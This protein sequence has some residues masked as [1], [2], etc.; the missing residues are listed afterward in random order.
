[1][2]SLFGRNRL[3]ER[4]EK[5]E[6][7]AVLDHIATVQ[8]WL[9]DYDHGTLKTDKETGR[10]Q[11]YNQDFF[12]RILGYKE[13]PASP[14]TFEPKHTTT[15]GQYPDAVLRYTDA[16]KSIDNISAVVELKGAKISLD[17][18]QQREGN[19][20]PVQ[21]AFKYKP[22]YASCPFVV[23]SNFWEFR[24]YNDNQLDYEAWTLRDLV[25][26]TDDYIKFKQWYVLLHADN[27]VAAQGKSA[28]ERLL[29]DIR[30]KQEDV[31]KKFYAEYKAARDTLLQDIWRKNEK[32][33]TNFSVAI[34]KAQTIIDRIMFACFAEDSG[35]LPDNILARVK[36][37]AE[38]SAYND[39]L[40][41]E[42]KDFFIKIDRGSSK[43]GIPQG[44]NGGL[45]AYDPMVDA[46]EISDEALDALIAFGRYDFKEDLQVNILGHIFE[47]SITDLEEIKRKVWDDSH[48]DDGT[49]AV[50]KRGKRKQDGIYYTPD[51]VVR[52]I[53]DN[54]VGAFL[55]QKE[56]ELLAKHKLTDRLGER[57]YE[58][59]ERAAYLEYQYVLQNIKVIDPA[60]GSGA[61]LVYVFDYLLA[62]NNRVDDI[63]GGGLYS[64][65]SFVR[66]IL[67]DNIYG[68]DLNDESVEITKLSLWLKTA[69]RDKKLTT[70][71]KNIKVGNSII[72]DPL[73]ATDKAFNWEEAFPEVLK[74]G[75][76]DVVV[77]N[78]P[79]GVSF[80][81]AE[82]KHLN[83]FDALV[84]DFE[85]YVYFIS[86][87]RKILADGGRLTY[88]FPNTFL[89]NVYGVR[90]RK[91]LF[92]ETSLDSLLDLS[93]DPTF[94]DA[95][96][97]TIVMSLTKEPGEYQTEM[98]V[99][100]E[101]DKAI[102]TFQSLNKKQLITSI[103]N[104][105]ALFTRLPEESQVIDKIKSRS[106]SLSQ[107]MDVSQGYIPY[108]RSDLVKAYGKAAG[109]S[110][111]DNRE[112]HSPVK[113][114]DTYKRD[115]AGRELN[116]YSIRKL[117]KAQ[118]VKYGPHVA[119]YVDPKFFSDPRIIVREI[120][121]THLYAAFTDEEL[122]T[123]PS[124]IN[125]V[126]IDPALDVQAVLAI[127]NSK[128][129]G[130]FHN[131]TSPKAKKGL[132]PKVLVGDVRN[133]PLILPIDTT[134]LS[135]LAV[136]M[137]ATWKDLQDE[138]DNFKTLIRSD[139]SLPA[140]PTTLGFWWRLEFDEFVKRLVKRKLTLSKKNDLLLIFK[141]Y[142][143]TCVPLADAF[144]N[145][146]KKVDGI[147]YQLYGLTPSE[148]A[149]V[150]AF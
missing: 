92:E 133:I 93:N 68:V 119:S 11:Q 9:N 108:R 106:Q 84:P 41:E 56:A 129:I 107:L 86:L 124:I 12:M 3:R 48:P 37:S 121:A 101:D 112:W 22:Q 57:G 17:R 66:S 70:L 134:E 46:L 51:Y 54:S 52:Y 5:I 33:R 45:F 27:M 2:A 148:I 120:T 14:F 82:K 64:T 72:S 81:D 60:C 10:E 97:R 146:D 83:S 4:A 115:L 114:D 32:T 29:T 113:L 96:V 7:S 139:L 128:L 137:A 19:L 55:R 35:L 47:Q 13:K 126:P 50:P 132:F 40:W 89:V 6:T 91:R 20:S 30:Q 43:L 77:G 142:K 127:V 23:V 85:I 125:A 38:G 110:I 118:Y 44:Y 150:E 95:S 105:L 135:D 69:Q 87:L 73:I 122:Y 147:V 31:G 62:E 49:L 99:I 144:D 28:T 130:W 116:R 67:T 26:P 109:D 39:S 71:D 76:F 8:T 140:W 34:Q 131:K 117:P 18:P 138:S 90:Y 75:G 149:M 61:F 21:Q 79:Y 143:E 58:Q 98:R 78:P 16:S 111:V 36:Q 59:R 88:I 141:R 102:T 25:D 24:L 136:G 104:V 63:I 103:D 15:I 80:S 123:N 65:D 94:A 145:L 1:M 42:L 53:V 74:K 100:D